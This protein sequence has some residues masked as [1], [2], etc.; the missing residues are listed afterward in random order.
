MQ[1]LTRSARGTDGPTQQYLCMH[2][3]AFRLH[4]SLSFICLFTCSPCKSV[5]KNSSFNLII[6]HINFSGKDSHSTTHLPT[7]TY[8]PACYIMYYCTLMHTSTHAHIQT[9]APTR[10]WLYVGCRSFSRNGCCLRWALLCDIWLKHGTYKKKHSML[11]DNSCG[12]LMCHV[13]GRPL[14]IKHSNRRAVEQEDSLIFLRGKIISLHQVFRSTRW[15]SLRGC[16]SRVTLKACYKYTSK[17]M[18]KQTAVDIPDAWQWV[19]PR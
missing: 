12:F 8:T 16:R 5:R 19:R 9:K 17:W 10:K 3:C 6:Y 11:W 14:E 4:A 1:G 2:V 7:H 13:Q 15:R 18:R